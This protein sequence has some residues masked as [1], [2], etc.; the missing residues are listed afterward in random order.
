MEFDT[1]DQVLL[2]NLTVK[3]ENIFKTVPLSRYNVK[4]IKKCV[5]FLSLCVPTLLACKYYVPALH[6]WRV[7]LLLA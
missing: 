1:E 6:V 3:K 2:D 7:Q 4:L 5:R